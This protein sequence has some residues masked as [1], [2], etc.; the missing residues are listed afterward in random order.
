M[1]EHM[2]KINTKRFGIILF[3]LVAVAVT[4]FFSSY[5]IFGE[6]EAQLEQ[7]LEDVATQNAL[8]LRNKIHSNHELIV[9]LSDNMHGVEQGEDIEERLQSLE[10]F[11][12]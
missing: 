6:L 5:A 8:A 3:V 10:I 2:R 9:S 4:I 1:K 12:D 7:N 11:L